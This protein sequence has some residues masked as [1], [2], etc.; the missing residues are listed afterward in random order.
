MNNAKQ[1]FLSK[2]KFVMM[3]VGIIILAL[4][5]RSIGW[6]QFV[7]VV[8]SFDLWIVA[9][10]AI[11]WLL[12]LCFGALRL[13]SLIRSH[14][15]FLEV[16]RIFVYGYLLNYASAIQ[17]IGAGAKVGLLKLKKISIGKSS[18]SVGLEIVYDIIITL[19]I[20][21]VFFIYHIDFVLEKIKPLVNVTLFVVAALVLII[22]IIA[23]FITRKNMHV[24]EFITHFFSALRWSHLIRLLP[25]SLLLWILPSVMMILFFYAAGYPVTFW[26]ALSAV[27]M[28]F[29]LGL[30]SLIPGGLGV[31]DAI[32]A[33]VYSLAGIPLEVT[34]SIAV[35]NRVFTIGTVL[36][37]II[38]IKGYDLATGN[39]GGK[40]YIKEWNARR[41]K[42]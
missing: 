7:G 10:A 3:I 1:F 31:R 11:P 34:I 22:M 14:L 33:Y 19:I 29:I 37:I 5:V 28:S 32:L 39:R 21:C 24:T 40:N 9:L 6:P 4:L 26:L 27:S 15:T 35:F 2:V 20:S 23:L 25:L 36:G 41:K 30:V 12:T 8:H 16:F 38:L 13:K 42:G 18:A 17:G